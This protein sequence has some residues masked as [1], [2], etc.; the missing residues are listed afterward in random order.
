M[1]AGKAVFAPSH[2]VANSAQDESRDS[3][4]LQD[5]PAGVIAVAK[6]AVAAITGDSGV[7]GVLREWVL[8]G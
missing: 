2:R 1:R 6:S 8:V 7:N 4:S 5:D 3:A